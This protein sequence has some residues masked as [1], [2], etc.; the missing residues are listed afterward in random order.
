MELALFT[1]GA[2]IWPV[3]RNFETFIAA[4]GAPAG[5]ARTIAASST[6]PAATRTDSALHGLPE[7]LDARLAELHRELYDALL[8]PP[9][10]KRWMALPFALRFLPDLTGT[11]A[12]WLLDA[13]FFY[14]LGRSAME[15]T[16]ADG[17]DAL[18]AVFFNHEAVEPGVWLYRSRERLAG[19]RQDYPTA[20]IGF[21]APRGAKL[22]DLAFA[23]AADRNLPPR[24]GGW[25]TGRARNQDDGRLHVTAEYGLD[26]SLA[27]S[28]PAPELRSQLDAAARD[29]LERVFGW[30]Q[31]ACA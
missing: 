11:P 16:A 30:Q 6:Y 18:R 27:T 7:R 17:L 19:L 31:E 24:S 13:F 23:I 3:Y 20:R 22:T 21:T 15:V 1:S 25:L 2:Y 12:E 9:G 4:L 28:G 10:S 26:P 8:T 5:A 14:F 29:V